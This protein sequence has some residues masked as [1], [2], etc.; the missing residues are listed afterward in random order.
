MFQVTFGMA[1]PPATAANYSGF[2][3]DFA[4]EELM[5]LT[6]LDRRAYGKSRLKVDQFLVNYL[7]GKDAGITAPVV[8]IARANAVL[9]VPPG[10]TADVR[11]ILT[12]R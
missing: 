8:E 12:S 10:G 5:R 11:P 9:T 6:N 7:M 2:Y 1:P 4:S 3:T